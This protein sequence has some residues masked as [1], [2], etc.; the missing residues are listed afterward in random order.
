MAQT[1]PK[2][3]ASRTITIRRFPDDLWT[4][5]KVAAALQGLSVQELLPKLVRQGLGK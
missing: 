5:V 2:P 4:A 3:K 1:Q